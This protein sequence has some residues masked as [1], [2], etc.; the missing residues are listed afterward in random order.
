M[1]GAKV[2][3]RTFNA[4]IRRIEG[5]TSLKPLVVCTTDVS[6]CQ[7]GLSVGL[8]CMH[9]SFPHPPPPRPTPPEGLL[10]IETLKGL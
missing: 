1:P 3:R 6:V 10:S 7:F 2:Q 4:I 5:K 8:L 9:I